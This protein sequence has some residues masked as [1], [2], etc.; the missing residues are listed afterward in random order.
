MLFRGDAPPDPRVAPC[1]LGCSP[2]AFFWGGWAPGGSSGGLLL[3]LL[4]ARGKLGWTWGLADAVY[5]WGAGGTREDTGGED[6]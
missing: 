3:L 4:V 1:G 5:G 6:R 2:L